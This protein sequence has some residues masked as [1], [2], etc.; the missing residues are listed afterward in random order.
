MT[1]KRLMIVLLAVWL[2]LVVASF[3]FFSLGDDEPGNG[4]GNRIEQRSSSP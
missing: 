2:L 3:L 1:L 4:R